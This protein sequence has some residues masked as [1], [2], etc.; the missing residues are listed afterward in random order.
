M[1][2]LAPNEGGET[3]RDHAKTGFRYEEKLGYTYG[4]S[5][6]N[7]AFLN[8]KGKQNWWSKDLVI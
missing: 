2:I 6:K 4:Q 5:Y 3:T 8:L 1:L 7:N